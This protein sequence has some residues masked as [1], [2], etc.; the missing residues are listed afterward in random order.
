MKRVYDNYYCARLPSYIGIKTFS[1][2]VCVFIQRLD[3]TLMR[4]LKRIVHKI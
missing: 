4:S 3:G 2:C 1:E